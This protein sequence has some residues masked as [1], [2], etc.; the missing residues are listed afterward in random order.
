MNDVSH[1]E[2]TMQFVYGYVVPKN[3]SLR[4]YAAENGSLFVYLFIYFILL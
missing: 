1:H 3:I 2:A 4:G